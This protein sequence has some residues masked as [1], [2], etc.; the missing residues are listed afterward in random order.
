MRQGVYCDARPVVVSLP[1]LREPL[2]IP[3]DLE[4]GLLWILPFLTLQK[5]RHKTFPRTY[6]HT[7]SLVYFQAQ[8]PAEARGLALVNT[9][10][11][12]PWW[13]EHHVPSLLQPFISFMREGEE[14]KSFL[15]EIDA[16]SSLGYSRSIN[17]LKIK[18]LFPSKLL[19]IKVAFWKDRALPFSLLGTYCSP[20]MQSVRVECASLFGYNRIFWLKKSHIVS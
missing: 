10:W 13:G 18:T 11:T 9:R 4:K 19:S 2:L 8:K 7:H 15:L 16:N 3:P 6:S 14:P 17:I 5:G 20:V 12:A 1:G